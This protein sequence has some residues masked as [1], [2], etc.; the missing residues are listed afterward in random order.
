MDSFGS[1]LKEA[2][3]KQNINASELSKLSGVGKNLISYYINGKYTAKQDKVYLLAKALNVDPGWL[4]TGVEPDTRE[5]LEK[6]F[7]EYYEKN[8]MPDAGHP[9]TT[10]ARIISEGI[11]KMSPE[12]REQALKVLQAIFTDIFDGSDDRGT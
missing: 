6:A 11:D 2:M 4:M 7:N 10:E 1:R 3:E 9:R 5:I 8:G 12:R